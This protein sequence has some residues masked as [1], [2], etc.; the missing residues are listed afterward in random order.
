MTLPVPLPPDNDT[1]WRDWA[2]AIHNAVAAIVAG[3][4]TAPVSTT[5]ATPSQVVRS[6]KVTGDTTNRYERQA[7]GTILVGPGGTTPLKTNG[8]VVVDQGADDT[9]HGI[10]V[11]GNSQVTSPGTDH[12][13]AIFDHLG[14]PIFVVPKAGGPALTGDNFRVFDGGEVFNHEISLRMNGTVQ[15]RRGDVAGGVGVF[16]LGNAT[17]PPTAEPDG[18]HAVDGA[19]T[20]PGV[21]FFAREGRAYVMDAG[22]ISQEITGGSANRRTQTVQKDYGLATISTSGAPAAT[23]SGTGTGNT[24]AV[25][26]NIF[27]APF[28]QLLTAATANNA[29]GVTPASYTQVHP[30]FRPSLWCKVSTDTAITSARFWVGLF[31]ASPGAVASPTALHCA[32]FRY[33]TSVDGTAF[34]RCVTSGASATPT[35]TTT[36]VA[37][38]V[39]TAYDFRIEYNAA[40]S[41]IRFFI[42][43]VVVATHTATLPAA[44]MAPDVRVTTLSA[45]A[46]ALHFS[47]YS[48]VYSG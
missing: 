30:N 46:R 2:E 9:R 38:A 8:K 20:V 13:L 31:S 18:T 17:T 37:V 44:A 28:V 21:V 5:A 6:S 16:A 26:D 34:W 48:L 42:N 45:A 40:A 29:N 10:V 22:G 43:D 23:F 7:D 4:Y 33:D 14:A 1:S 25:S 15:A 39:S 11:Y 24:Q 36:S 19:T 35:V 32:A 27:S 3:S 41:K 12:P 47:R